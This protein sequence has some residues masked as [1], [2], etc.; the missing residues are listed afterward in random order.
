MNYHA[1]GLAL[2]QNPKDPNSH[3]VYGEAIVS[4]GL[5][6]RDGVSGSGL[7]SDGFVWEGYEI[8]MWPQDATPITTGWTPMIGWS[9]SASMI[10]TG[11]TAAAGYSGSASPITTM[12]TASQ[13][14]G[15][16]F[17]A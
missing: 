17:P 6:V 16:E 5:E 3:T 1:R 7:I 4:D 15:T 14:F 10:A 2:F 8:W 11:W 9:G 12:W 13:V